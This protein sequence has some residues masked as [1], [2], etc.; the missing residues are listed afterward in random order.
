MTTPFFKL[1]INRDSNTFTDL[2]P[3]AQ[4][5]A[6]SWTVQTWKNLQPPLRSLYVPR[7]CNRVQYKFQDTCR[8]WW[9]FG[10]SIPSLFVLMLVPGQCL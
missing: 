6:I 4:L 2:P 1:P 9:E 10:L 7:Y 3:L 5:L 8:N